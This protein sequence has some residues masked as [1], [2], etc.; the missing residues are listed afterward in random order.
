MGEITSE[1][2]GLVLVAVLG[3]VGFVTLIT[4]LQTQ[5]TEGNASPVQSFT[6]TPA[7]P[8]RVEEGSV[9]VEVTSPSSVVYLPLQA[10]FT[11]LDTQSI[12]FVGSLFGPNA[13]GV[14]QSQLEAGGVRVRLEIPT[15]PIG[16]PGNPLV[17]D[18]PSAFPSVFLE[19]GVA[20][21]SHR[22]SALDQVDLSNTN[23]SLQGL[24]WTSTNVFT[25]AAN[26]NDATSAKA[27]NTFLILSGI[28]GSDVE[29][30]WSADLLS[31]NAVTGAGLSGAT[32]WNDLRVAI[33]DAGNVALLGRDT[34]SSQYAVLLSTDE[35]KTFP[36]A[37]AA[38]VTPTSS[39]SGSVMWLSESK[40]VVTYRTTAGTISAWYFDGSAWNDQGLVT[41]EGTS[42]VGCTARFIDGRVVVAAVDTDTKTFFVTESTDETASAWLSPVPLQFNVATVTSANPEIFVGARGFPV[43]VF[44]RNGKLLMWENRSV[45]ARGTWQGPLVCGQGLGS[46]RSWSVSDLG[47]ATVCL[48]SQSH[49]SYNFWPSTLPVQYMFETSSG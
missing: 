19:T 23:A 26:I 12:S 45:S 40:M 47:S 24:T 31:W 35:G 5:E 20:Y 30:R 34:G 6:V 8:I 9:V 32:D 49:V 33:G 15:F 48:D 16:S 41:L 46:P 22:G 43:V 37:P 7:E 42:V 28:V 38:F 36:S 14:G 3:V 29:G 4:L 21:V 1:Q 44:V 10:R 39:G 27:G 2:I 11:R 18:A 13:V 17:T 25:A